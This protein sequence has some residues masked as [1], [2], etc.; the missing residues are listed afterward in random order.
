VA[1]STLFD[2]I[3]EVFSQDVAGKAEGKQ[4]PEADLVDQACNTRLLL[5]EDNEIN[6]EVATEILRIAGFE[7]MV[8]NNGR[9]ALEI[10]DKELIDGV[11]MDLTMPVM[12]GYETTRAIR[13]DARFRDLPVIAMTANMMT[14]SRK[15]GLDAGMN[16]YLGKPINVEELYAT[17]AKWIKPGFKPQAVIKPP[18]LAHEEWGTLPGIDLKAGLKIVQGNKELYRKILRKFLD[19]QRNF[20]AEL[21]T[22]VNS[23]DQ[24]TAIRLAHTMKGV[25]GNIGAIS[26]REAAGELERRLEQNLECDGDIIETVQQLTSVIEGLDGVFGEE[27]TAAAGLKPGGGTPLR[28]KETL[29]SLLSSLGG[30]LA[31]S[32]TRANHLMREIKSGLNAPEISSLVS[33]LEDA[34]NHYDYERA[35]NCLKNLG[36]RLEIELRVSE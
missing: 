35:L 16:D 19:S 29:T 32:D 8:A 31:A 5:V 27:K 2:T 14:S 34:V 1:P 18:D 20:E 3:T 22:A 15:K 13:A 26:V 25:A 7:V 9:E 21:R 10:L 30:Y 23:G 24:P 12:D 17:L 11:L 4:A 28:N 6:Q 36:K 33:T